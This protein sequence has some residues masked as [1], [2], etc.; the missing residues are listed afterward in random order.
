MAKAFR[1]KL[2]ARS[3]EAATQNLNAQDSN[4]EI[5]SIFSSIDTLKNALINEQKAKARKL[6]DEQIADQLANR[7]DVDPSQQPASNAQHSDP[8][9]TEGPTAAPL[10]SLTPDESD[11]SPD[12]NPGLPPGTQVV[13][14]PVNSFELAN[15]LFATGN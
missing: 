4:P 13:A 14:S 6:A 15:S 12:S 11:P 5:D 2:T 3:T 9:T 10:D 7:D 8:P 1:Q